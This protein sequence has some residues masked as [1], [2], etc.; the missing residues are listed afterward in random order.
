[1]LRLPA[2]GHFFYVMRVKVMVKVFVSDSDLFG[3]I[4]THIKG[5]RSG[6]EMIARQI[7]ANLCYLQSGQISV[8]WATVE[9][10]SSLRKRIVVISEG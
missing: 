2:L 3:P 5:L 4:V 7:E 8:N 10:D 6:A 1:M 9:I